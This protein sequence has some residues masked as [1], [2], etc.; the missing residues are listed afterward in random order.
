[1]KDTHL[2]DLDFGK[3]TKI[4]CSSFSRCYD[5]DYFPQSFKFRPDRWLAEDA[6]KI[7]ASWLPF[8]KGTRACIGQQ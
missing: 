4:S 8:S 5:E 2:T 7:N 1:M 6:N 3:Q